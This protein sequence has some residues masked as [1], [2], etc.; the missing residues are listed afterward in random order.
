MGEDVP[1]GAGGPAGVPVFLAKEE[2]EELVDLD[3]PVSARL[4]NQDDIKLVKTCR[5]I[6]H[7]H[8]AKLPSIMKHLIKYSLIYLW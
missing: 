6:V 5:E 2:A 8:S 1:D 7:K 4:I 3:S